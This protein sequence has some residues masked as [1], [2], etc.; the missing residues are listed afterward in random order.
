METEAEMK[1][2]P[3]SGLRLQRIGPRAWR[4]PE[5]MMHLPSWGLPRLCRQRPGKVF[6]D[7][8]DKMTFPTGVFVGLHVIMH[9][10]HLASAWIRMD[11]QP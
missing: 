1:R 11:S 9:V 8:E 7:G 4:G 6:T 2:K 5:I 3:L 10:S